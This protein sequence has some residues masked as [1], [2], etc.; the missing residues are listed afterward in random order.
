[1]SRKI[2]FDV[3]FRCLVQV[4]SQ[5]SQN[6]SESKSSQDKNNLKC[7]EMLHDLLIKQK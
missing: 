5:V 2:I 4:K 3:I 7:Q 6:K 1:M